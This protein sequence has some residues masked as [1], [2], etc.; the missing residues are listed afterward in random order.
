MGEAEEEAYV[1][2]S[3]TS[4]MDGQEAKCYSYTDMVSLF[5]FKDTTIRE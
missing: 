1:R 2:V 3:L 4:F 5:Q